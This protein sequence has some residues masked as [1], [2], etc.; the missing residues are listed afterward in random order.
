MRDLTEFIQRLRLAAAAPPGRTHMENA[1]RRTVT[2]ANTRFDQ[3]RYPARA[4]LVAKGNGYRIQLIQTGVI[5]NAPRGM[6]PRQLLRSIL[7][8]EM[9]AAR[10]AIRAD[11]QKAISG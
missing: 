9:V 5:R 11:A 3:A 2:R 10:A 6:T 4:Q 8:E 1:A 7:D